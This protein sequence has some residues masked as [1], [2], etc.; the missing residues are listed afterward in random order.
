MTTLARLDGLCAEYN[1]LAGRP[2]TPY[3][4]DDNIHPREGCVHIDHSGGTYDVAVMQA[5][6]S[7]TVWHHAETKKDAETYLKGLVAA[8]MAAIRADRKAKLAKK[9]G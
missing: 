9:E 2:V 4:V 7:V 3:Q 6:G 8:Q 5:D 1:V